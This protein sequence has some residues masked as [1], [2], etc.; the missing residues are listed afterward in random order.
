MSTNNIEPA[1]KENPHSFKTFWQSRKGP[2]S[3]TAGR[4]NLTDDS[5]GLAESTQKI[6]AANVS[7]DVIVALA[8]SSRPV[9]MMRAWKIRPFCIGVYLWA[10]AAACGQEKTISQDGV[11]L[12]CDTTTFSRVEVVELKQEPL[13][14][15]H[16]QLNVHPANLLFLFYA[17]ARYAGSITLY[18]LEDR[19]V[20]DLKGA[21]PELPERAAALMQMLRDRPALPQRYPSSNPKE[22]PT[23]QNQMSAQYFL[24]HVR[25]LDFSWGSAIAF[26]VQ[27]SQDASEYAV[28]SRLHYQIE[29]ITADRKIAVSAY[30]DVSHPDLPPTEKD[31]IVT[32]KNGE[33]IGEAAYM[34]YLRQMETVLDGKSET[35]FHPPLESIQKLVGS[36]RFQNVDPAEWGSKFKGK[37]TV[38]GGM[39]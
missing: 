26:L 7:P 13:P 12:T 4:R 10:A 28:G 5:I 23:I 8:R 39:E 11:F 35:T 34:K 29:G 33:P 19:S 16:D 17:S 2:N 15:P 27:Y 20:E 38:F 30:F 3:E 25:Y 14:H 32:D 31:G 37:K 36:L 9:R 22:I 24:N 18:P 6:L 1:P 21:Y